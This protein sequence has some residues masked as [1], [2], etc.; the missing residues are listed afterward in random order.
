MSD[1]RNGNVYVAHR[2]RT[3]QPGATLECRREI[4][5]IRRDRFR[6]DG[7]LRA[8]GTDRA[9]RPA[10]GLFALAEPYLID[11]WMKS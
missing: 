1:G 11:R 7:R 2:Q 6:G 4:Q 10:L 8:D 5:I 3:L 9:E